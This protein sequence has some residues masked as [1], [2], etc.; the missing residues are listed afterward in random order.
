MLFS[1]QAWAQ[2]HVSDRTSWWTKSAGR[3]WDDVY[4]QLQFIGC[5]YK[6]NHLTC[7]F[8]FGTPNSKCACWNSPRNGIPLKS[9]LP[10]KTYC[11]KNVMRQNVIRS[12][13]Q[14]S[15]ESMYLEHPQLHLYVFYSIHPLIG[16]YFDITFQQKFHH[17]QLHAIFGRE[18]SETIPSARFLRRKF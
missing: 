2:K 3:S 4:N 18:T 1:S 16:K 9:F 7:G 12:L 14:R 11:T 15:N 8:L 10:P 13:F 17:P 6:M 5:L